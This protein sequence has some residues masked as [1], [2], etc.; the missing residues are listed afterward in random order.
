MR[1]AMIALLASGCWDFNKLEQSPCTDP[2]AV[3]DD[4]ENGLN[5]MI[6][7]PVSTPGSSVTVDGTHA[8][9]TM[10]LHVH[11]TKVLPITAQLVRA[12]L[13]SRASVPLNPDIFMRLW[14]YVASP[15]PSGSVRLA[16]YNQD[17]MNGLNAGLGINDRLLVLNDSVSTSNPPPVISTTALPTDSWHCL[18]FHLSAQ[19]MEASLDGV[20]PSDLSTR[21]PIANQ[22]PPLDHAVFGLSYSTRQMTADTDVWF[23]DILIDNKE[24][25]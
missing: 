5:A 13:D 21:V 6:W 24:P 10:A 22:N 14:I 8:R 9:G 23:D 15:A 7:N 20:R 2:G 16:T 1:L 3:C 12:Q 11:L 25:G 19:S 18:G 4:F 17:L